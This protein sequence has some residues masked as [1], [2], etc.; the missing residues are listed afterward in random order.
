MIVEIRLNEIILKFDG[1]YI[2]R[3]TVRRK[4][5]R[6]AL[7]AGFSSCPFLG[8][9]PFPVVIV[10]VFQPTTASQKT[11]VFCVASNDRDGFNEA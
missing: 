8:M 9:L 1:A 2:D 11:F 3:I 7:M 10:L 4:L 6:I 5:T